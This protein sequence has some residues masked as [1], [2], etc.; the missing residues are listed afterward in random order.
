[1]I[2]T[3]PRW[4]SGRRVLWPGLILTHAWLCFVS[5]YGDSHPLGDVTLVYL[6]WMSNGFDA[7]YWVG[8][9]AP[10][11]YPILAI[12]PMLLAWSFG[13]ENYA[14]T[15]LGLVIVLD[16]VAFGFLIG[17]TRPVRNVVAAWWWLGFLVLLGPIALARLDS[18]TVPLAIVGVLFS[19]SRPKA[20]AVILTVASW[21]KVWPGALLVALIV[22]TKAR[23]RILVSAVVS[24]VVIATLALLLGSGSNLLSFVTQQSARG[25]QVEA[26]VSTLWLWQASAGVWHARVY[27]DTDMLTFQVSGDGVADVSAVMTPLLAIAVLVII[28]LAG[29]MVLGRAPVAALL[30]SLSLA[31]VTAFI[32]FNKV[33]SPQYMSWL[34]V[35]IILGLVMSGRGGGRSF[36]VP[37]TITAVLAVLTQL[38]YP[39]LYD[40]LLALDPATLV[41]LTARNL[42][43]FV[44]LGWAVFAV[45]AS[46]HKGK[47]DR[48]GNVAGRD[49]LEPDTHTTHEG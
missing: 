33:G 30:P 25:L 46:R 44:L 6:P 8:L 24:S 36:R 4:L 49:R 14:L 5:L 7:H 19:V 34:A 41:L 15:W 38:I 21:V 35:P 39:W 1:M 13:P 48:S 32:A 27:Y 18:V 3:V 40:E 28:L 10:W 45:W 47:P 2:R 26:P 29:L 9:D 11:V 31:L 12:V 17:W 43:V 37:A 20:A 16:A 23:W 42:L 22:A